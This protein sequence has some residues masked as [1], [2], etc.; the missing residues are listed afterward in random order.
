[1]DYSSLLT[2]PELDNSFICDPNTVNLAADKQSI[3]TT[4]NKNMNCVLTL[5][6]E[7]SFI[8]TPKFSQLYV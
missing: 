8:I 2:S 3:T 4:K 7:L 5:C 1:M 6:Q